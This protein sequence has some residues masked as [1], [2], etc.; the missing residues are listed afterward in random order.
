MIK[1]VSRSFIEVEWRGKRAFI[2]GEMFFVEP[3]N[4]QGKLG[5]V[6]DQ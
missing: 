2:P 1:R 6:V 5:F 3:D 4:Q